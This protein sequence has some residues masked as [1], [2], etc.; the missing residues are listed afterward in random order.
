KDDSVGTTRTENYNYKQVEVGTDCRNTNASELYKDNGDK[1]FVFEECKHIHSKS[2]LLVRFLKSFLLV[3]FLKS[4]LLVRF[5]K[6]F[7][8]VRFL[9][10]FLLVRV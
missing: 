1:T 3:R 2:F 8:L 9:K 10:S 6:S 5:F 4:F 7:L